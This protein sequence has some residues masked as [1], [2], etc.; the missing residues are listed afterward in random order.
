VNF[1]SIRAEAVALPLSL[2]VLLFVLHVAF[3]P[4]PPIG[5]L[6]NGAVLGL[7]YALIAAGLVLI[8]RANRIISFAQA[9]LGAVPAAVALHLYVHQDWPFAAAVAVAIAGAALLGAAVDVVLIRRFARAPR[10]ILT[11]ATIGLAQLLTFVELFVPQWVGDNRVLPGQIRT[12]F[13]RFRTEIGGY[14]F[15]G[16]HLAAVIVAV[17]AGVGVAVFLR[18]TRIGLAVRASAENASRASLM[19]I[20]VRGVSTVVWSLAAVLSAAGVLLRAPIV[21]VA[22]PAFVKGGGVSTSPLVLLYALAIAVIARMSS[23]PMVFVVGLGFG[24][25]EQATFF[26]TRNANLTVALT[27]PLILVALLLQRGRIARAEESGSATWQAVRDYKPIPPELRR[28]REVLVGSWVLRAVLVVLAV[29]AP[30]LVGPYRQRYLILGL[31]L[32]LGGISLVVLTGWAGQIS[33]GQFGFAAIG[34]VVSSSL[35]VRHGADMFV[36]LVVAGIVGAAVAV[37]VGIPALRLQGLFLAVTTLAFAAAV[38]AVLF[39]AKYFGWLLPKQADSALRPVLFERIDLGSDRAYYYFCLVVVALIATCCSRLRTTRSGRALISTRDYPRLAQ[40]FGINVARTRMAAFAISGFIASIAGV[41]LFYLQGA[42]DR[43]LFDQT[44]SLQLFALTVIGG[45]TSVGGAVAG[46]AYV[47]GFQYLIPRYAFL[48]TG[49]GMLLLL[50]YFPGGLAELGYRQRDSFLRWVADRKG[51]LVPSLV[52]DKRDTHT[53]EDVGSV[54]AAAASDA[55]PVGAGEPCPVCG[56]ESS[57]GTHR[58]RVGAH[59]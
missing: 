12:P 37:V 5:I 29:A 49:A 4:H 10:L 34:A 16:D 51:L 42:I 46:A 7:L 57:N 11:V 39:D 44:A 21:G 2:P 18:Y 43:T 38:A 17:G 40:A 20:P 23:L 19:G 36:T 32:A 8:Y 15:R 45:I 52:A 48:A 6:L 14:F 41:L 54:L 56:A 26:S 9:G 22:I 59:R 30:F 13:T 33:L 24:M 27:L 35:V 25:V 53:P 47:V 3:R 55:P 1:K 58:S 31:I 28:V 50:V